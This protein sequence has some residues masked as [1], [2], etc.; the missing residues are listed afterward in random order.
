M[1]QSNDRAMVIKPARPR[2]STAPGLQVCNR[3]EALKGGEHCA[4]GLY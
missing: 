2:P 1:V 4:P 3:E